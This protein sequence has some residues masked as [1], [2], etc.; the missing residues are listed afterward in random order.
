VTT[1]F[2][3]TPVWFGPVCVNCGSPDNVISITE[4]GRHIWDYENE[5]RFHLEQRFIEIVRSFH[6]KD[7]CKRD[8]IFKANVAI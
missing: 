1:V 6:G 3:G 4:R 8:L 5:I 2:G 7:S